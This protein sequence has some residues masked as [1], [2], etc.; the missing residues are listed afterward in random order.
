MNVDEST[1]D[2]AACPLCGEIGGIEIEGLPWS[3]ILEALQSYTGRDPFPHVDLP[4]GGDVVHRVSCRRCGLEFTDPPWAGDGRFYEYL[5]QSSSYYD[6]ERWDFLQAREYISKTD[7]VLDLGCG[8]GVFLS[9]LHCDRR[10]GIDSNPSAVETA[11]ATGAEVILGV[12]DD[13]DSTYDR[14][15]DVVCAFQ[16][17]EHLTSVSQIMRPALRLARPH[18]LIVLSVPNRTRLPINES[19]VLDWPPHHL[20]RWAPE[21]L[22]ELAHRWDLTVVDIRIERRPSSK[23]ALLAIF[24]AAERLVGRAPVHVRTVP[25]AIRPRTRWKALNTRHTMLVVLQTNSTSSWTNVD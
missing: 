24:L 18:G 6:T 11:A 19:P 9:S 16:T 2:Q 1:T 14:S 10:V 21:Q 3:T 17:L 23:A 12:P 5:S 22:Y 13:V 7:S 4:P 15:F 8:R 25:G 20:S